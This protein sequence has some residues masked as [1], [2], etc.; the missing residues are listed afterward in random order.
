MGKQT[1]NRI[2]LCLLVLA[3]L[4]GLSGCASDSSEGPAASGGLLIDRLIYGLSPRQ[5]YEK[6]RDTSGMRIRDSSGLYTDD[7]SPVVLY[8]TV[9]D[10][11]TGN[12][13]SHTWEELN[14]RSLN[15]YLEGEEI[16]R[17]AA[18]VQFGDETGPVYGSYG[19]SDTSENATVR[20]SGARAS[21]R[22]Q[23][24]YR[25]ELNENSGNIAGIKDFTL[26][27]SFTDPF[28]MT[29]KLAFDLLTRC[30]ALLSTRTFFVHLYVRDRTAEGDDLFVD[31]GLY[32]M[33][34]PVNR[35]YLK[36]RG[37]DSSGELYKA[38][39]FDFG[40]HGDVIMQPTNA[41]YSAERFEELLKVRGSKD[42]S[43]LIAMLEAV[44]DMSVPIEETVGAWFD[45]ASL[46]SF[47]A[48]NLLLDNKDTDTENFFLYRP[49]GHDQFYIIP[50]DFDG[51]LREN[52]ERW[53][54]PDYSPGWEKGIF[55]YTDSVLFSRMMSSV[56][57]TNT[58]SEYMAALHSGVFAGE[59]IQARAEA[60]SDVVLSFL[61]DLPDRSY[62]RVTEPVYEQLLAGIAEQ[63]NDNFYTYYDS[64][65]TPWPF[66][67]LAPEVAEDGRVR[68]R[69]E[70]SHALEGEVT[71]S[72]EL[73][74]SWHFEETVLTAADLTDTSLDAGILPAGQYFL[75]VKA[76]AESGY[77]Q[78]A[79]EFYNTE[80]KSVVRG[81]LCFYIREKK[82]P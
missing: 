39:N 47:L 25:I 30:D 77:T 49:L 33:T 29:N 40:R 16:W 69:W 27:K 65:M 21:L 81:V 36:N 23:K 28:R 72:V 60:L 56:A 8:L 59:V 79:Y 45:E 14:A 13:E 61:Y 3:G 20:L 73:S 10:R 55:L 78:E 6:S 80:K 11:P 26:S 35:R 17:C 63:V 68:L 46:Y 71:Y 2:L 52:Y 50:W 24:S 1:R 75:R 62:A 12:G 15:S 41:A 7:A 44:N 43:G 38:V 22:Q 32:T 51:S 42:Y 4:L 5:S 31:Y 48:V 57:C 18:L 66:H 64:L 70:A 19:F 76:R 82:E 67:I 37:L 58:L 34:E 74:R 9:T 54:D 53:R